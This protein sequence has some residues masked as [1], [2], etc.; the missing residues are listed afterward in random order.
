MQI[1]R[2]KSK[3]RDLQISQELFLFH[4][5]NEEKINQLKS[6]KRTSVGNTPQECFSSS[7]PQNCTFP[8]PIYC[9]YNSSTKK[10]FEISK[11]NLL[12]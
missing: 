11:I 5:K 2:N 10:N 1:Y 6:T 7:L 3:K 12:S 4:K 9:K 8:S